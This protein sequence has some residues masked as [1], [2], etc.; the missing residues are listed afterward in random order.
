MPFGSVAWF[1]L[2]IGDGV[3]VKE[4][5]ILSRAV[6]NF[7][8]AVPLEYRAGIY[9]NVQSKIFNLPLEEEEVDSSDDEG[10]GG[11]N[12]DGDEEGGGARKHVRMLVVALLH[13]RTISPSSRRACLLGWLP[14][15][16][17]ADGV[18][19]SFINSLSELYDASLPFESYQDELFGP[20]EDSSE[21]RE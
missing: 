14:R 20:Q 5:L 1:G 18:R 4:E 7:F 13:E 15:V 19:L 3:D 10:G 9:T 8:E 2:T 21:T 6:V 12:G 11:G 17:A 16:P